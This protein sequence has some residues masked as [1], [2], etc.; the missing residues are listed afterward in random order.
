MGPTAGRTP[1]VNTLIESIDS[2]RAEGVDA[3]TETADQAEYVVLASASPRR[4]SLLADAG[5]RF[6]VTVPPIDDGMLEP[7]RVSPA[8]WTMSLAYLKARSVADSLGPGATA[9]ILA[10]DTV[11]A[12]DGDILGQ[13][14]DAPSARAMLAR[15]ADADHETITGVC[16]L[17]PRT[18]RRRVIVDRSR[19]HVGAIDEAVL[20]AYV[21]SD[22]WRGKAGGYN[23]ADRLAAGWPIRCD[24]DPTTVMGLPMRR[25]APLWP[26]GVRSADEPHA[27]APGEPA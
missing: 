2:Q 13:P 26:P 6:E 7:G 23:L 25:L 9:P 3:V 24:G 18:G 16:I 10:A 17:C 14:R 15:L 11:C 5:V 27:A 12:I 4:R 8:E 21:A 1:D 19:V 20:D 22:A